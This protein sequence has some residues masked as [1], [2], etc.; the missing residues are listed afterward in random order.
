MRLGRITVRNEIVM[1]KAREKGVIMAVF[2]INDNAEEL[3]NFNKFDKKE[4]SLT[5]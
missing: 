4:D 3:E 2:I 5:I 1:T